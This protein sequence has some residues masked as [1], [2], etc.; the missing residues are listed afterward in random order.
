MY[1]DLLK[2]IN[3][4][5]KIC[6]FRHVRPDGDAMFS[7]LAMYQFIK[8]NFRNKSVKVAGSDTYDIIS[9]NDKI[10]DDFIN[11]S[12]AIVL[13]TSTI[14][15]VDDKRFINSKYIIKIDH[16]PGVEDFGDLNFVTT[17]KA[18]CTELLAEIFF[19]KEFS[20]LNLSN[21]TCKYLYCGMLTDSMG[22][23]TTSTTA[24][25]LLLG[26]RLVEKGKLRIDEL[27]KYVFDTSIVDF[28]KITK[29]RTYLK[30]EDNFGY[31]LLNNKDL[32]K[33][34][35]PGKIAR[36]NIDEIAG[37]KEFRVWA[38][39]TQNDDN[40][41]DGSLRCVRGLKVNDLASKFNGG[42]H[43]N[44][45]G[46]NKLNIQQVEQLLHKLSILA[47]D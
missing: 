43:A 24:N 6:I 30:N 16:H 44:A 4:F 27:N 38:F 1:K 34:G 28:N 2:K 5:D 8:D 13:D 21:K 33:I 7:A 22:F 31:I 29:I 25:T 15:R 12:L 14:E 23:I 18:S 35:L 41:Y 45:A 20:K 9:K 39:F 3:E 11:D 10:S 46:V 37:I 36:N 42:G 32:K 19:S 40:T 26:S 47:N 17:D